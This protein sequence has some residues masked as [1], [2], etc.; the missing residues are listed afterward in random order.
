MRPP[1]SPLLPP[2]L[3][4]PVAAP[5]TVLGALLVVPLLAACPQKRGGGGPTAQPGLGCP[6]A[7]AVHLASYLLPEEGSKD[8]HTGWVL[9]LHDRVVDSI[10]G[11]PGYQVIDAAAAGEAGVPAPPKVAWLLTPSGP[12]RATIGGYYAAAIDGPPLN[13]AYGVELSG[14]AAP[15]DPSDASAIVLAYDDGIGDAPPSDCKVVPPRPVAARL[16]EHDDKG[17]WSRPTKETPIPPAFAK[18]LPDRPC[19]P[20]DCEKLWSVAEVE[21]GGRP[22]AWAGAVNW[23]AIPPGAGPDTQCEWKAERFSG[24][25]VPG[26]D[27]APVKVTEAQEH[28][29]VLSAVLAD[30]GGAKVLIA[31]APGEYTTYDLGGGAARVGRHLIWLRAHPEAYGEVDHLGPQCGP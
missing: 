9:P 24:F 2:R 16:G 18:V 20:P 8:G 13:I 21:V 1:P 6:A 15:P 19:A 31:T 7:S 23:L 3:A 28:A 4:A 30:A 11:V 29:L 10:E 5:V 22:V 27:G 17:T 12:C 26:S 25:F 14:C